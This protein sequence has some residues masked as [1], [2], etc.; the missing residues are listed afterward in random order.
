MSRRRRKQNKRLVIF[1]FVGVILLI[2]GYIVYNYGVDYYR[3]YYA[4]PGVKIDY[5]RYPVIGVDVASHQG[6]INWQRVSESEVK[7]AFIKVT[8]GTNFA[9][10]NFKRN[11]YEAKAN[12]IM[13]GVYHF[14][15]FNRDG[16]PQAEWFIKNTTNIR[17]DFPPVVDIELSYG[18][19]FSSFNKNKIRSEIFNY[20]R[21][22][23]KYYHV[24]PIIYTNGKTWNE[25]IK[26]SFEEYDLWI[27]KLCNE[28]AKTD[29][30]FWQYTHKGNIAGIDNEVDMN[31]FNGDYNSFID[32][33]ANGKNRK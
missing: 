20:L 3:T 27:C 33:I 25:F 30:K 10:A 9:D 4:C 19:I 22:I 11:I 17:F 26:G 5:W 21:T 1:V 16:K 18:N 28:P 14:F 6:K 23:E 2:T 8:E 15:R 13:T 7:F 12:G 29:W 31:T 32:Y 24:K